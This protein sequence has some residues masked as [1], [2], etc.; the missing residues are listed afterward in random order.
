[1]GFE[2]SLH[3][4]VFGKLSGDAGV[5]ALVTGVY[6]NVPQSDDSGAG[7]AFP[8]LTVGEAA[9]AAWDTDDSLG[10]D[11][12]VTIHSWSRD[13]GQKEIREIQ[14]AVYAALQRATLSLTG[15]ALVHIDWLGSEWFMDAD[16]LTRH[17]VQT[18]RVLIDQ[19]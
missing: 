4:A 1:M 13:R 10:S 17:G 6:D 18:F 15:F 5:T 19:A 8:Y 2:T 16:G 12:T 9:H 11:A 3:E 7:T 14:G